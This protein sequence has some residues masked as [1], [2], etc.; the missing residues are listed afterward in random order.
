MKKIVGLSC[1][2]KNESSETLLKEALMAAEELGATTELIRA[3]SLKVLP[4]I[5]CGKCNETGKC[6]LKDDVDWILEKCMR[7]DCGLIVSV[8]C[9][10]LRANSYATIIGERTN[11]IFNA[12]MSILKKT[13]VGAMIGVGGSGYDAWAALT[14]PM[15]N[16]FMQHTRVLVD[17]I[18]VNFGA[19]KEWNLWDRDDMTPVTHQVRAQDLDY[20]EIKKV[21]TQYEPVDFFKKA[22]G[23]AAQ[24]GRNVARAMDRPIEQV[25]YLG[26]ESGVS[27]PVCHSNLLLVHEDLPYVGCPICWVRGVVTGDGDKMKVEWNETDAQNP[28]FSYEGVKHHMEW[29]GEHYLKRRLRHEDEI[30]SL[31]QKHREYGNIIKPEKS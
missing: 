12:D 3:M 22:M 15:V 16:I 19:Y 26:E 5:G 6:I 9:Y 2:R 7:E 17:K 24:L 10:H 23:R 27:C 20:D 31:T 25:E 11:H 18:Q 21:W 4:C 28:R 14:N 1:G 30:K 13:R 29:I 8:P